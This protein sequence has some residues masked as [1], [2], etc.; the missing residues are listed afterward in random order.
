MTARPPFGSALFVV[1]ASLA[2]AV[3][4]PLARFARPADPLFVAFG[5]VLLASLLLGLSDLGG[6]RA[7]FSLELKRI[8]LVL[9]AG[10]LLATHFGLFLVGLD[11]TSLPAAMSLVSLEPLSVVLAAWA[12]F[13]V[14]PTFGEAIGIGIAT[15]GAL[16]VGAAAGEGEHDLRGDGLVVLAVALY[17]LY[18]AAARGVAPSVSPRAYA[19]AVYATAALALAVFLTARGGPWIPAPSA[20]PL[21]SWL[22]IAGLGLIPT[23][24]GH[25]AVQ[26][27]A[28]HLPPSVVALVSPGETVGGIP[29]AILLVGALPSPLELVGAAVIV[30]GAVFTLRGRSR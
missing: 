2:F 4:G 12:F 6:L 23:L 20:L 29:L 8:A 27:A 18:V 3:A 16:V 14:R 17:G 11:R 30:T 13:R 5:R 9:V 22:A 15:V 7:L 19:A 26:I 21:G 28:R 1:V 24:I 25:T 10:T